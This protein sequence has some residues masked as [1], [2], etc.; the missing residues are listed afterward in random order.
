MTRVR[1]NAHSSE[2]VMPP[3]I[4]PG[5][6]IRDRLTSPVGPPVMPLT[7]KLGGH[8]RDR[9]EH[10]RRFRPPALLAALVSSPG[11]LAFDPESSSS[12]CHASD[13]QAWWSGYD[14]FE[15]G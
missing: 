15:N 4:N 1:V 11:F 9:F 2:P 3:T 5:G 8:I 7:T 6:R 12:T 10:R 13:H 14:R